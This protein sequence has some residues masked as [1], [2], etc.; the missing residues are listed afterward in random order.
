MPRDRLDPH[1]AST[2]GGARPAK[3]YGCRAVA[4]VGGVTA[5]DEAMRPEVA[6]HNLELAA[7]QTFR[8]L[9]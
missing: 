8:P 2:V 4:F 7:G 3:R 6:R 9:R 1:R 5:L